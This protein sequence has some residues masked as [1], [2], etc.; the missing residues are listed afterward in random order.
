VVYWAPSFTWVA[1][2]GS[3]NAFVVDFALGGQIRTSSVIEGLGWNMP[4][5]AW[6]R[7]SSGTLVYWRVRGADTAIGPPYDVVTSEEIR[8]FYKY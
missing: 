2:Y 6:D 4:N 5:A 1:D 3:Q 7:I 8:W